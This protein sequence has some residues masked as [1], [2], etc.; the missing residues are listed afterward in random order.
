[1][2]KLS[3]TDR[4]GVD[5][6][7]NLYLTL[8]RPSI[9]DFAT[10]LRS[11]GLLNTSVTTRDVYNMYRVHGPDVGALKGK[12]VRRKPDPVKVEAILRTVT[13][14]LTL[15]VDIM[16]V[17][18]LPFL[19]AIS[20]RLCLL[21]VIYLNDRSMSTL[22]QSLDD[23]ISLYAV[24]NFNVGTI[25]CD[26]EGAIGAL[27]TYYQSQGISINPTSK[28]EHVPEI[29]RAI[30]QVKERV[31]SFWSTLPYTLTSVMVVY[32]V[33]YS[34]T[35]INM[36]PKGGAE[37][38]NVSPREMFLGRKIDVNIECR[39]Q[40]GVYV[41]VH[42]DDVITNTMKARTVGAIALGPAGN[43]QGSYNFL[44]LNT[45]RVI[46]RRSWT[47]LPLP[48]DVMKAI[49]AKAKPELLK[50]MRKKKGDAVSDEPLFSLSGRDIS[51]MLDG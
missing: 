15:S 40:F 8:G 28:D 30:R 49:D 5:K 23:I 46:R 47:E 41:Q 13:G 34:V 44:N 9:K 3:K 19:L 16:F 7:R 45:W 10:L 43:L 22:K 11:G 1:M 36:F 50:R 4:K 18:G 26:G 51:N 35:T 38:P 21:S 29:E 42:E 37:N 25:L 20:R 33:Q 48:T 2:L 6:A 27:K 39:L 12:T 14:T 31:R 24:N 32:L 17:S